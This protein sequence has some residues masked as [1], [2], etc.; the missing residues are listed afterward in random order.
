MPLITGWPKVGVFA[1][2][3]GVGTRRLFSAGPEAAPPEVRC[4]CDRSIRSVANIGPCDEFRESTGTRVKT[5][6]EIPSQQSKIALT[7]RA[8][9]NREFVRINPSWVQV[10]MLINPGSSCKENVAAIDLSRLELPRKT[11]FV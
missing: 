9:E 6:N 10:L 7:T 11:T 2:N 8:L 4:S 1:G 3:E 5:P